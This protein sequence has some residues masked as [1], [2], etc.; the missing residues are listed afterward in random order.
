MK[1]INFI[2]ILLLCF[3][4]STN[5][6]AKKKP[7][8]NGVYWELSENGT[9][10]ISGNG[11]MPNFKRSKD[12]PWAKSSQKIRKVIIEEGVTSI[13][14]GA[15]DGIYSKKP[16]AFQNI[17]IA[18]TVKS[19]GKSAFRECK[20]SSI[21][22]PESLVSI[23]SAAFAACINLRSITIPNNVLSIGDFCFAV[24]EN[25]K[26]V[27]IPE[28]LSIIPK[29]CFSS[30]SKLA[31]IIFPNQLKEI[32]KQA[33]NGCKL[34]KINI[35]RSV[36]YIGE[37][38]F[39][40]Y[41]K[42]Y[43]KGEITSL[44]S[45]INENNCEKCGL[46]AESVR[47]YKNGIHEAN[48]YL[49]VAAIE[50]RQIKRVGDTDSY[51]IKEGNYTGVINTQRKWL[52]PWS[53]TYSDIESIGGNYLKV[54]HNGFYGVVTLE[55]KEI[56]PT[57]REYTSIDS[58]NSSKQTF[59]FTK[60]GMKGVC[61]ANGIEISKTRLAPTADDIK[62]NGNYSNV[63]AMTNGSKKYY[64][65]SKNGHYGLT[66]A[67][68]RMI[69]PIEMETLESAGMGYLKFKLNGFWGLM[70]YTGKIII[71][72]SRGYTSIGEFISFTKRFPYTMTGYKGECDLTGKEISRIRTGSPTQ[73]TASSSS[74]SSSSST[75]GNSGK[76]STTVVVEHHRDPIPVQEWQQCFGCYGSG[77]CTL[78][79]GQG[80]G[81]MSNGSCFRCGWSGK[82]TT[83]AGR[84][85]QYVTVYR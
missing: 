69:V 49:I 57:N 56:I 71:D 61:N 79:G 38:A 60:K 53:N 10:T 14:D 17:V 82:C 15:F 72:T 50:G 84:G 62:K 25:L 66:D 77:Q 59:A 32:G 31:Y 23:E 76:N 8:G 55:G 43:F 44:P 12:V 78:C 40:N 24:C 28:S 22:L 85:G 21:N 46:S 65:V 63:I 47:S 37:D 75:N 81:S 30:C 36:N 80:R 9:L 64:K 73:S 83:C 35:P 41:L 45:F 19:I 4:I 1:R 42:E 29:Y 16:Y 58:Y 67:E 2:V 27:H 68:G 74:S 33:F 48:G 26:D 70:D 6:E 39:S 52:I 5:M 7:L 20:F 51:I 54:K 18:N 34:E 13:G 11:D 3:L